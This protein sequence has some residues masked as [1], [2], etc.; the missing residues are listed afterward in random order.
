[1]FDDRLPEALLL[2]SPELAARLVARWVTP[3]TTVQP[4]ESRALLATLTAWVA[5]GGSATRTAAAVH[6]HRNTDVNRLRRVSE[7]T[8]VP[9]GEEAPPLDL[10]LALRAHRMGD[11]HPVG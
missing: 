6:C 9:L 1:M 2:S 5:Q 8:G 4:G 10:D 3:L 7:L 11:S